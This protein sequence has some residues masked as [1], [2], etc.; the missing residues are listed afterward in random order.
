MKIECAQITARRNM[1]EVT[2]VGLRSIDLAF[3]PI[4]DRLYTIPTKDGQR[5]MY[6]CKFCINVTFD[7]YRAYKDHKYT[8][9][10]KMS[11]TI[12]ENE[13]Q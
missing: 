11:V 13:K 7:A 10:T 3:L 8:L 6:I 9:N 4:Q 2:G 12:L 1:P 5:T